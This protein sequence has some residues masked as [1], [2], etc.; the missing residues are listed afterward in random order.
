MKKRTISFWCK[1]CGGRAFEEEIFWEARSLGDDV[2]VKKV[3][4]KCLLCSRYGICTY[5]E[6]RHLLKEIERVLRQRE[7]NKSNRK[8]VLPV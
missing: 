3:E 6:Y 5:K 2:R 7:A 8:Q 4:V 1:H